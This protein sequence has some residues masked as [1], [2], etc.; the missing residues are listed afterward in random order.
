MKRKVTV[1]AVVPW[2][3]TGTVTTIMHEQNINK[4]K[5]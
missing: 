2:W 3:N 5:N 4:T 1:V